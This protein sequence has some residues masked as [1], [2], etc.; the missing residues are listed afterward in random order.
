MRQ[1]MHH[2]NRGDVSHLLLQWWILTGAPTQLFHF[3]FGLHPFLYLFTY[4]FQRSHWLAGKDLTIS[5]FCSYWFTS[6]IGVL[7][8]HKPIPLAVTSFEWFETNGRTISKAITPRKRFRCYAFLADVSS[9]SKPPNMAK[10]RPV[11]LPPNRKERDRDRDRDGKRGRK[12]EREKEKLKPSSICQHPVES[13]NELNQNCIGHQPWW[14]RLNFLISKQTT[15][16]KKKH[17]YFIALSDSD[18]NSLRY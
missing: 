2:G 5:S 14:C 7:M 18:N 6:A 10:E 17:L 16:T 13:T 15:A 1:P 3:L 11:P 8:W 9:E 12:R 4:L